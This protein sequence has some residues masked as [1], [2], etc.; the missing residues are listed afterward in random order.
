MLTASSA[1]SFLVKGDLVESSIFTLK[2]AY[3][4]YP[5]IEYSLDILSAVI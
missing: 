2:T 3:P 1:E 4:H 5:L